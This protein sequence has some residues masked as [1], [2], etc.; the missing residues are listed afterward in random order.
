[1]EGRCISCFCAGIAKSC[2]NTG[3]YRNHISLRFTD[4]DDFKGTETSKNAFLKALN[5]RQKCE[6]V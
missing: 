3:R 1:M 5:S 4:A 2:R 6:G